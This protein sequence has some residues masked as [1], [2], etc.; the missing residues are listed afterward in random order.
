[1][2]DVMLFLFLFARRTLKTVVNR[3]LFPGD[4]ILH[5]HRVNPMDGAGSDPTARWLWTQ[6]GKILGPK[7]PWKNAGCLLT[8]AATHGE[9][10]WF[11]HEKCQV[12]QFHPEIMEMD[13]GRM[14][15]GDP[16]ITYGGYIVV[17]GFKINH[18]KFQG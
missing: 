7:S 11:Y 17:V 18:L 5:D 15:F 10:S 12:H 16:T 14:D 9:T 8:C 4:H 2:Y 3:I 1:M 6:G 13:G